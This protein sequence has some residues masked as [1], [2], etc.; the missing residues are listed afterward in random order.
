MIKELSGRGREET[1]R[2]GYKEIV[3][4]STK[5]I[6]A[7]VDILKT[8]QGLPERDLRTEMAIARSINGLL[9]RHDL[10]TTTGIESFQADGVFVGDFRR[11]KNWKEYERQRKPY[12]QNVKPLEPSTDFDHFQALLSGFVRGDKVEDGSALGQDWYF[13]VGLNRIYLI[14][15][16]GFKAVTVTPHDDGF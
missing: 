11:G 12:A 16:A 7:G 8:L 2:V 9:R 10:T 1:R 15:V 13:A 5:L 3:A 4:D 6:P 14:P